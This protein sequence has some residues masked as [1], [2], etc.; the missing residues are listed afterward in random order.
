MRIYGKSG[1]KKMN[2]R[3]DV[4]IVLLFSLIAI[5]FYVEFGVLFGTINTTIYSLFTIAL[6]KWRNVE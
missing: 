1:Q 5:T 4:I 2:S 6:M 3:L